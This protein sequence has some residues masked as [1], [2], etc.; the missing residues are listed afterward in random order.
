M[1]DIT[2]KILEASKNKDI[3][4]V[5]I[6]GLGGAGKSTISETLCNELEDN[7]INTI[8]LHIDN[9]IHPRAVRYNPAYPQWQCYYDLQW[10]FDH[11]TK[12]INELKAGKTCSVE[13]YDKDND[14]YFTED[15]AAAG[16]TVIVVEGIFLQRKEYA[17]VFDYMVYI[18]IPE[19]ER[20]TRVLKRDTYIGNEQEIR[21]KYENRYFPAER[22]YFAEYAPDKNADFVVR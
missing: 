18:D 7:D 21:D 14:S 11:F 1:T 9:L 20:L 12:V 16:K 15:Y 6:D 3:T 2:A 8:L 10:R 19:E 17:G 5:G 4:V 13:L 22:R